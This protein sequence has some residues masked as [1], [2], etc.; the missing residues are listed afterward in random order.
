[1]SIGERIR[2]FLGDDPKKLVEEILKNMREEYGEIPYIA[3]S[4]GEKRPETFI[5]NALQT[6]FI[7]KQPKAVS[8][9][10]AELLAIAAAT[11][12]GC[13][14]CIDFHIRTAT[15]QFGASTDEIFDAIMIAS[16]ISQSSKL[17]VALRKLD[18]V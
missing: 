18:K 11:A 6:L 15:R 4:M 16:L 7:M 10:I 1:M 3:K 2:K 9:K 5:F 13:E 17:A 12:I 14:H 8:P